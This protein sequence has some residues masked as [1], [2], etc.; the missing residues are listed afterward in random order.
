MSC[1]PKIAGATMSRMRSSTS[2]VGRAANSLNRWT[3]A[4]LK[5]E[6]ER[7]EP[8]AVCSTPRTRTKGG[9]LPPPRPLPSFAAGKMVYTPVTVTRLPGTQAC[10]RPR[11]TVS[12]RFRG[13]SPAGTVSGASCSFRVWLSTKVHFSVTVSNGSIPHICCGAPPSVA[14]RVQRRGTEAP[15]CGPQ[16]SVSVFLHVLHCSVSCVALLCGSR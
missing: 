6:T 15:S 1:E 2:A 5:V 10:T 16:R 13:I 3:S 14:C 7:L 9:K 4:S 11:S 12:D 8:S